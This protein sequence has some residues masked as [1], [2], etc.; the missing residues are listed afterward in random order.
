LL[1]FIA[2]IFIILSSSVIF[3]INF[4]TPIIKKIWQ[5]SISKKWNQVRIMAMGMG[6]LDGS[7]SFLPTLLILYFLGKE[8]VL[9]TISAIVSLISMLLLYIHGKYSSRRDRKSILLLSFLVNF[10]LALFLAIFSSKSSIYIFI[11]FSSLPLTFYW[12]A[13]NPWFLSVMDTVLGEKKQNKFVVIFDHE[14]FLN[15]GRILS[16]IISLVLFFE[17]GILPTLQFL[18][19]VLTLLQLMIFAFAYLYYKDQAKAILF[20]LWG[21]SK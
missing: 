14:I 19:L 11:L 10:L 8:N 4:E 21:K 17:I 15:L 12:L 18:P 2:F 3:K 20:A 16:I 13:L 5:L 9:G 1:I 7:M 6:V